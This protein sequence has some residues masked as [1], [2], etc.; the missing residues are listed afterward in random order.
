MERSAQLERAGCDQDVW[1]TEGGA[2]ASGTW[3][4][5]WD[6]DNM[7]GTW[8]TRAWEISQAYKVGSGG[9]KVLHSNDLIDTRTQT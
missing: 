9:L 4:E 7:D 3:L 5:H 2:S 1:L 8:W 6:C